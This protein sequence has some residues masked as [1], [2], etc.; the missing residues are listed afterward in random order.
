[1]NKHR[2]PPDETTTE[3]Q[4]I[5][6]SNNYC[7]MGRKKIDLGKQEKKKKTGSWPVCR[8]IYWCG[9]VRDTASWTW[10]D[11]WC[12]CRVASLIWRK[13]G[14][15]LNEGSI[16][17]IWS[18]LLTLGFGDLNL[19]SGR[20]MRLVGDYCHSPVRIHKMTVRWN[21]DTSAPTSLHTD[22]A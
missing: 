3:T 11:P 4:T 12:P 19:C 9:P 13:R 20:E 21:L 16:G 10:G 15:I 17:V 1:M 7:E 2:Y 6:E 14:L 5:I 18:E 8:R 22:V